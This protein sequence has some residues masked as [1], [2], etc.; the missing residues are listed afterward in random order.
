[1]R[2]RPDRLGQVAEVEAARLERLL[3]QTARA[4][5]PTANAATASDE[6]RARPRQ[7][8]DRALE[9]AR[10][11]APRTASLAPASTS[12]SRLHRSVREP[13][14]RLS[15]DRCRKGG[16]SPGG[17]SSASAPSVRARGRLAGPL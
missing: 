12:R 3:P 2:R 14:R 16:G 10:Q 11:R 7:G 9:Q 8:G 5:I 4:D 1:M 13:G 15:A 6:R 17:T